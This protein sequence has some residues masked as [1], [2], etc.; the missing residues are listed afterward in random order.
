LDRESGQTRQGGMGT[1]LFVEDNEDVRDVLDQALRD[2]GHE[3]T[4]VDSVRDAW[5]KLLRYRFDLIVSDVRLSDG[6]AYE[7]L[8]MAAK[9]GTRVILTT[10]Y[11]EEVERAR[12]RETT[13][14]VKPFSIDRFLETIESRLRES[15]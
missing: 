13:I 12:L 9:T 2:A 8:P 15:A 5:R 14:L 7:F 6:N 1:I 3:T 11:L 10:G 4:C